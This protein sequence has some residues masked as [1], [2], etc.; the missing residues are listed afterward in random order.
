MTGAFLLL[1]F[2]LGCSGRPES[3]Q[4]VEWSREPFALATDQQRLVLLDLGTEWCHWCHVMHDTTYA[5]PAVI[6]ELEAGYVAVRVDADLRP[7]L[8]N[9]YE[10]YGWPATVIFAADGTELGKFQGYVPPERMAAILAAFRADP[11][12]GPSISAAPV[13]APAVGLALPT[14]VRDE[15]VSRLVDGWDVAHGGWGSVHKFIDA[16][17]VELSLRRARGG[18]AQSAERV[19]EVLRLQRQL[20]D[21]VWGGVYQY[22]DGGVWTNPHFEKIMQIQAWNLRSYAL[23]TSQL[24]Q[25]DE[26]GALIQRYL[27]EFM[28]SPTKA[29]YTSQDADLIPGEHAE[30]YFALDDAGRRALGIPKIDKRIYSRENGWLIEALALRHAA[31]GDPAARK[32]AI[33][34]AD[35][36][37][38]NRDIGDGGFS[39]SAS[40]SAGPYLGDTVAMGRAY[41]ALYMVTQDR[42]YLGRATKAAYFVRRFVRDGEAGLM[43]AAS[44][45]P[46]PA[47]REFDENCEAARWLNLLAAYTGDASIR[48]TAEIAM[49]FV[50]TPE[51]ALDQGL[52][53]GGVLLAEREFAGDP[54]H[55]TVVGPFGDPRAEVLFREALR[56]PTTYKR[57]EWWDP[58]GAPLPRA[59]V[60]YP[61][62][63][64][65]AAFVCSN[66]A[67]SAPITDA[68][69]I[70]P[71]SDALARRAG[72]N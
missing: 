15:L 41:L 4:W 52:A 29:F 2:L 19:L 62:L 59:D 44:E 20:V 49:A 37:G 50:V 54:A 9:R 12:P 35:Y 60:T 53:I 51:R 43:T 45:G 40:D 26:A 31:T 5:D 48:A 10:D 58:N 67:C 34:A 7:D 14:A 68:A 33:F 72:W 55:L 21:P 13:F 28:T 46:L 63:D 71:A 22:S 36:I 47:V 30:T 69:K 57:V 11:T 8:A 3:L 38:E 23:A 32:M 24:G 61:E 65:P 70:R 42:S 25:P 17:L 39:H 64:E 18:D 6:A 56:D 16:D 66:G 1:A 27:T